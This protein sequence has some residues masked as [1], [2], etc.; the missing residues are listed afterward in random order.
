MEGFCHL[1]GRVQALADARIDPLDRGFL[2]GDALYEVIKVRSGVVF[3]LDAHLDRMSRTFERTGIAEPSGLSDACHELVAATGMDTGFLY[4][5]VTRGVAPRSHLPP[6]GMEPTVFILP[7]DFAY[8][9][10][11]ARQIRAMT[12]IDYRWGKCH[13]KTTS[14]IATV[15]GKITAEER[16]TDE[17]LFVTDDGVVREGGQTNFFVVRGDT[18]ET[19]PA[20]QHILPGVTRQLLLRFAHERGLEAVERAPRLAEMDSWSEAL[21][22]GTL[23]GVQPVVEIDGR[24]LA[25]G[26]AGPWT[27]RLAEA[28]EAYELAALSAAQP[29]AAAARDR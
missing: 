20:D 11:A 29:I 18:L 9:E 25:E 22:C 23:T 14:L 6:P 27:R 5:Q 28:N 2:F 21:I 19:H 3:E 24:P 12:E 4:V 16:G 17:I 26:V 10:P 8:D 7:S 15:L 1:D 13:L